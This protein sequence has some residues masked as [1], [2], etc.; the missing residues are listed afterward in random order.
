MRPYL[1][2]TATVAALAL[3]LAACGGGLDDAAT[4]TTTPAATAEPSTSIVPPEETTATEATST[5]IPPV[6]APDGPSAL[7]AAPNGLTGEGFPDPLIDTERLLQG[8]V[9]DGIPAIDTPRFVRIDAADEWLSDD[10]AV[11]ILDI[12][13]DVR[14]YPIQILMWHEIVN[15][16]VGE[17]PVAVTYCPLC[18]SAVSYERRVDGHLTTFGTSGFLF[19]SALV[20]YDRATESLWTHFD[21]TAVAGVRTGTRLEP[22]SSPLLAWADFKNAH[23]DGLVLDVERTGYNRPYGSNPY[24]GYD[25]P[26]SFPF[27]FDGEVDDRAT[28]K[29]RVVGVNVDGFS[30]AWTLEVISG[31]GPTTT[32]AAVGTNAVVVFWKPGQASA[33][34]SSAIAAGRDVGSVR[35]FRPQIESQSLTFESTDD[36]FV[37]A[38]TGSEWNIL[39]EAI[40]GPLAG[41]K[42]EPVAHLDTFWF[43][44]LSYNPA[45]EFMGS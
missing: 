4:E 43:A 44:W 33:L 38:E 45:T 27:L 14:A 11:V 6:A 30:M 2:H 35:V 24:S 37:D 23:A 26:E 17:V 40:N 36:G 20:M 10:E 25:N 29:Q 12:N 22:I 41:E 39:G 34:D 8:Q 42:L 32:H 16:T 28:A 21:G 19:N 15:D 9:P 7:D 18:N 1:Q 5:T 31:E 13:G 3:I